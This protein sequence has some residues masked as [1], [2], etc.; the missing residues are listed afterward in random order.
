MPVFLQIMYIHIVMEKVSL[1]IS[2]EI[3]VNASPERE[4]IENWNERCYS[5]KQDTGF[6]KQ[7]YEHKRMRVH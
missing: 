1:K 5:P 7:F 2:E 6:L 4:I 3:T